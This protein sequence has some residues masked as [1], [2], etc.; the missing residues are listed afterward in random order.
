MCECKDYTQA[1]PVNDIEEFKAK[2]DQIAGKNVKGVVAT[3]GAL[4][5]GALTYAQSNGIGIVRILPDDQVDWVMQLVTSFGMQEHLDPNEFGLALIN[6]DH[7]GK[8]RAFYSACDDYAFGCWYSL[9]SY[10]MKQ[11]E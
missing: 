7:R 11:R 5:K 10:S 9:L 8:N 2:L 3:Q 1:I 6:P 4:Q